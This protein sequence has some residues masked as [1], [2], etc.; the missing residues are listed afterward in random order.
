M[1]ELSP[2]ERYFRTLQKLDPSDEMSRIVEH[3]KEDLRSRDNVVRG[4]TRV[5]G[6]TAE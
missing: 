2:E 5:K 3:A 4:L 6:F 1:H